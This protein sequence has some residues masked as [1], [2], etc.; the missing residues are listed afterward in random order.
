MTKNISSPFGNLDQYTGRILIGPY[1]HTLKNNLASAIAHFKA[2]EQ[3]GSALIPYIAAWLPE[4][5]GNIWYEYAGKTLHS[6]LGFHTTEVA[7]ALR[8]NIITR[9]LYRIQKNPPAIDKIIRDKSQIERMR[10]A[11]RRMAERGGGVDAIYKFEVNS[12]PFWLKD[13][14]RVE[15]HER[16]GVVL[17]YGTLID[18][19]KEMQLEE[20]LIKVQT[21]L[22]FHKGNLESL[23]E[24]RTRE[25]QKA[26]LDV[27]TRLTQAASFRDGVTGD[28]IKRLSQYCAVLGSSCGLSKTAN[29]VLYHAVPMHDV[30]KLGIADAILQKQGPLSDD[31]FEIIKTHCHVGS[32]LLSKGKSSLLRVAQSIALSH[33]E[34]W[35]G[36]GYPQGL[37]DRQI[38]LAS[39]ITSICDVFDAL[40][41]AR[42][43]K[44][45]WH[46]EEAVD[47][48]RRQR[49]IHFDPKI[50]DL[51]VK[52]IPQ[53]KKVYQDTPP[54]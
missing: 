4:D 42:P 40:T 6:L 54:V 32:D 21:E 45:A 9:C 2:L 25:L 47:E 38:P 29:T 20:S 7:E 1:S 8:D 18:V 46:F 51:F 23:V 41:S 37:T 48:I 44:K 49:N 52:K 16:E 39:R 50:V 10:P 24:D 28:H 19:T 34:R 3:L 22:E 15:I 14:S 53:I 35:D 17:S 30:G 13:L 5:G 27:L 26:Q 12:S 31:E 33:H 11:L 43:Y 36:S